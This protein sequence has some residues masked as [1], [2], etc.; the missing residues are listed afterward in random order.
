MSN[1]LRIT[2]D[3]KN[4]SPRF[5]AR[6]NEYQPIVVEHTT[7]TMDPWQAK[8]FLK[9]LMAHMENYEK[10]YG[11]ANKP[12]SVVKFEE[13]MKNSPTI[14]NEKVQTYFG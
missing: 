2:F 12:E 1:P 10:Q 3:F 4:I 8:E 14:A 9:I 7:I 6:N 11:V 13:M 5:D